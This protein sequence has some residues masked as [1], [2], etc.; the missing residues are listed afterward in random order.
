MVTPPLMQ[1]D[2]DYT[3]IIRLMINNK[4]FIIMVRITKLVFNLSHEE[5]LLVKRFFRIV[6]AL[7][8]ANG[9]KFTINYLKQSRLLITRYICK[10]RIYRNDHFISSKRGFPTKFSFLKEFIDSGNINKVKFVLTLMN[11][12]RAI[13]LRKNDKVTIDTSSITNP[14]PRKSIYTI[15]GWFIND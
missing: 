11:I 2:V 7:L 5:V 3:Q 6:F 8:K 15:P 13:E 14:F 4:L 10:K 9:T 1:L 12:S